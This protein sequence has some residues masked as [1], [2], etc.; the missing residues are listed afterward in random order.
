MSLI[1]K[2][3]NLSPFFP[4]SILSPLL[5]NLSEWTPYEP[6]WEMTAW[7]PS[8]D[9]QETDKNYLVEAD[10]PGLNIKDIDVSVEQNILTIRGERKFEAKEKNEGMHRSERFE[11]EFYRQITLPK[12]IDEKKIEANYKQGVLHLCLPKSEQSTSK[13][14]PVKLAD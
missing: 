13:R 2:N 1:K 4:E 9:V 8:L 14:I 7:T 12:N 6:E 11:G 5:K 10:L 3:R